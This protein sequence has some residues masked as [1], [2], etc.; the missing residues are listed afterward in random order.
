MRNEA[1]DKMLS[2][3]L[4][5]ELT[6]QEHQRVRLYLEDCEEAGEEYR[7]LVELKKLTSGLSFAPPPDDRMDELA[8]A[9]SVQ[10]PRR[11]GWLFW[12]RASS[13]SSASWWCIWRRCPM[14]RC[15]RRRSSV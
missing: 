13:P 9:L 3:Y 2:A 10:A 8:E 5:G 15:S 6:Q 4:D 7:E 11:M 12:A 14:C 1:L